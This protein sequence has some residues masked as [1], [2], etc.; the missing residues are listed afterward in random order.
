VHFT[1][2][3]VNHRG[4]EKG[5]DAAVGFPIEIEPLVRPYGVWTGN[6]FRGVVRRHGKPVPLA[7]VE[8]E[9]YNES[10]RVALPNDA[11][12]TQVIKADASGTFSYSM[13]R[14]GWWGF[15]ALV[16]GDE[17]GKAPDGKMVDVEWGGV[18][19]VRTVPMQ[20]KPG[21]APRRNADA[22]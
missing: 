22:H 19:W 13:P 9:Y 12:A 7:T 11:F 1:K 10:G 3:V 5:W 21:D 15:A 14:S 4:V 20:E 8:V 2:V 16:D 17:K 6:T 18:I